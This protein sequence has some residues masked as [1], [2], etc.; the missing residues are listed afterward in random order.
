MA[1]QQI[2]CNSNVTGYVGDIFGWERTSIRQCVRIHSLPVETARLVSVSKADEHAR[3]IIEP[4]ARRGGD[5]GGSCKSD[6]N[7]PRV[8]A[9]PRLRR[10]AQAR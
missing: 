2:T 6:R 4:I 8:S 5:L 10:G 3:I 7:Q 9:R 1:H